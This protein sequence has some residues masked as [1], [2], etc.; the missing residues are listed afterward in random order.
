M[1]VT[2]TVMRR[3]DRYFIDAPVLVI[4]VR[5]A[6]GALTECLKL[7][8]PHP[9]GYI[10][11]WS[12][13]EVAWRAVPANEAEH[14]ALVES[15]L[16]EAETPIPENAD[17]TPPCEPTAGEWFALSPPETETQSDERLDR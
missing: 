2:V 12:G 17:V 9:A 15:V 13:G 8:A 16:R 10:G 4:G 3:G 7:A 6:L 1:N 11:L 5:S 14:D